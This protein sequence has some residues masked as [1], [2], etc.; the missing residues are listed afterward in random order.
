MAFE[1]AGIDA[2]RALRSS[3][4]GALLAAG[5]GDEELAQLTPKIR[6][7]P[8]VV[9]L[10]DTP[11][12][13]SAEHELTI[14][15]AGSAPLEV[16]RASY[17]PREGEPASMDLGVTVDDTLPITL[18]VGQKLLAKIIHA[19]RDAAADEGFVRVESNDAMSPV[20]DVPILHP[21]NGGVRIAAVPDLAIADAEAATSGGVR[22]TLALLDLGLVP[23]GTAKSET[24]HVVNLAAGTRP[25]VVTSVRLRDQTPGA[26]LSA[27]PNPEP[28]GVALPVL[29]PSSQRAAV[30]SVELSVTFTPA[31]R[32]ELVDDVILI[33]S[34]DLAKPTLEIP[35]RASSEALDP[36]KLRIVPERVD[37]GPVAIG[38]SRRTTITLFNDGG[39]TLHVGARSISM[40][41]GVFALVGTSSA[42][43][44]AAMSSLALEVELTPTA[45]SAYTA[46]L[47]I[48]HDDG[49][50]ATPAQVPLTGSGDS[51]EMCTAPTTDPTEPANGQCAGAVVRTP[52]ALGFGGNESRTWNDAILEQ[53]GDSDWSRIQVSVDAGC[54]LTGYEFTAQLAGLTEDTEVCLH[55]GHCPS[56]ERSTCASNGSRA[57][58]YVSAFGSTVC[59]DYGND[60]PVLVEVRHTSGALSCTPYSVNFSAR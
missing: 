31:V 45:G 18:A 50:R 59:D 4:L 30:R 15:S 24:F 53:E 34:S 51:V 28:D 20:L 58:I 35:L 3:V 22:T 6:T 19:P 54:T 1:A 32:G 37:F 10:A 14:I 7:D 36:P 8:E 57:R 49:A 47:L 38:A 12:G 46:T 56:L 9:T 26:Q 13:T 11:V 43:A 21:I 23:Y 27:T 52:I 44:I 25:L 41:P 16:I 29:G 5:C 55:I 39:S 48:P 17:V 2:R 42:V 60:V 40:N 33:E